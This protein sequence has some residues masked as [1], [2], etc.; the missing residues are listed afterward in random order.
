MNL[1][2]HLHYNMNQTDYLASK[3]IT[4]EVIL[5]SLIEELDEQQLIKMKRFDKRIAN[6]LK[7]IQK[8]IDEEKTKIDFSNIFFGPKGEA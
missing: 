4:L 1:Q 2:V 3:I 8:Q 5:E 6:K 7:K